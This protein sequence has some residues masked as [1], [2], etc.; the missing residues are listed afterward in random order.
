MVERNNAFLRMTALFAS[1]ATGQGIHL[2][3]MLTEADHAHMVRDSGAR[4]VLALEREVEVREE[5][6]GEVVPPSARVRGHP[7]PL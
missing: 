4:V 2:L 7:A 3:G 1:T 5:Q 6:V